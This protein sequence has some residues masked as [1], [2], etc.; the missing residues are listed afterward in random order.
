VGAA[1]RATLAG[2][3]RSTRLRPPAWCNLLALGLGLLLAYRL[4]APGSLAQ[5]LLV[6]GA[7]VAG[8]AAALHGG[9][10]RPAAERAG[11]RL[12][13]AGLGLSAAAMLLWFP[14]GSTFPL[15]FPSV[16]DA[17]FL[18]SYALL[19]VGLFRLA[20]GRTDRGLDALIVASGA[21]ALSFVLLVEPL[22]AQTRLSRAG[23]AVTVAYP[24]LDLLLLATL[25]RLALIGRTASVALR[26]LLVAVIAQLAADS[27][28]LLQQ[29]QG[30][31]HLGT[32]TELGWIVCA[33]GIGAAALHPAPVLRA[34]V[35]P[36]ADRPGRGWLVL[37]TA[38]SLLAPVTLLA[39]EFAG[40]AARFNPV[41]LVL[42]ILVGLLVALRMA[43]F[44]AAAGDR[45]RAEQ[46]LSR[47][48][49]VA[50]L[51]AAAEAAAAPVEDLTETLRAVLAA[52]CGAAGFGG[53]QVALTGAAGPIRVDCPSADGS[54]GDRRHLPVTVNGVELGSATFVVPAGWPAAVAA[55]VL[56]ELGRLLG[57]VAQRCQDA[58]ALRASEHRTRAVLDSAIDAFVGTDDGGL[59]TEWNARAE[60]LFGWTA[61]EAL[62]RDVADLILPP[63]QALAH[64]RGLRRFL[65]TGE[66]ELVGRV[67]ELT[68]CR[69]GGGALPVEVSVWAGREDGRWRFNAFLRDISERKQVATRLAE[70][71]ASLEHLA[72]HD[73]LTGLPNRRLLV[74]R[75]SQA[76]ARA[77][78]GSRC[79]AV[80]LLDL[81]GF[82][83]INDTLGHAAGDAVLVEVA[84][85]LRE[86]VR[87]SDTVSRLGGDEFAI[88]VDDATEDAA[89][90]VAERA[91]LTLRDAISVEGRHVRVQG[92]LGVRFVRR[93]DDPQLALRDADAAMY[94]AK[95]RGR[96]HVEV[97]EPGM[98]QA[99]LDRLSLASEL[100]EAVATDQLFVLY[101]PIVNLA[102]G[103][104]VGAEALVRW[105]HPVRGVIPPLDFI[106]IA[107]ETGLIVEVGGWVL[108]RAGA[109]LRAWLDLYPTLP[110]PR[111]SVNLSP[112][113]LRHPLVV[114]R[115]RE[116][117]TT[118][119]LP[120]SALVLEV[121]ESG[122]VTN[123]G[124]S[125]A[126]LR[127]LAALGVGIAIDDFGTGYSSISYLRELPATI[128]K[129][130]RSLTDG[131]ATDANQ[132]AL[133]R[134]I[135][136]L[137][138]AV[139]LEVVAEGVE[140][141]A[142]VA[143]LRALGCTLAQ[144]YH[145]ARPG[146]AASMTE[147][148]A[149]RVTNAASAGEPLG[150]R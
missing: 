45:R 101:Q 16:V 100:G 146:P 125:L 79:P 28:F 98:H 1:A 60:E 83:A 140:T 105:Q 47:Q 66:S 57:R 132:Y 99:V 53:G 123:S 3:V 71:A 86:V 91:L 74:D 24:M 38:A 143:H 62:G 20:P 139:G 113:E 114:E 81:D 92:S 59:V 69:R 131:I 54:G 96:G 149:R 87:P 76:L 104:T 90:R 134:A 11:W 19:G 89:L 130:D 108:H 116:V 72:F 88:V 84:R 40:T 80:L 7:D 25:L 110:P 63:Q 103:E 78:R 12:L 144:G 51:L 122:L 64:R 150:A 17:G 119:A 115:V 148:L 22:L 126:S 39:R 42:T 85:R 133:T 93:E 43:R 30:T 6:T 117:L 97:F 82:K 118:Y 8:A 10:R 15:G 95:G 109:Q 27:R 137:V 129:I 31:F 61:G 112:V 44:G 14:L 111:V 41:L 49:Q 102:S 26:L 73:A 147:R 70:Q 29:G 35:E 141:A 106:G 142:Q 48:R 32:A 124:D 13:A 52:V 77:R 67:S 55:Q 127:A 21:A 46:D 36:A 58:A 23:I 138:D 4:A 2:R 50:V 68:L 145:F 56:G 9:R 37:L 18:A 135:F 94:A 120:P 107:E 136:A 5:G 121:T 65:R 34:P 75:V 128:V 33:V